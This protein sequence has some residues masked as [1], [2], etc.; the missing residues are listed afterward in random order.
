MILLIVCLAGWKVLL[1]PPFM[2]PAEFWP[3]IMPR[4]GVEQILIRTLWHGW[5][6]YESICKDPQMFS[7][8][9]TDNP[10]VVVHPGWTKYINV[11][12]EFNTHP[13]VY[14]TYVHSLQK[15]ISTTLSEKRSVLL[16]LPND[17]LKETV[18][19]LRPPSEVILVP[20]VFNRTDPYMPL[21][22]SNFYKLLTNH[23][24]RVE[25][26][27]EYGQYC[28]LALASSLADHIKIT[29]DD[30][31]IY[32]PDYKSKDTITKSLKEIN[33]AKEG[34]G[35]RAAFFL[36]YHF[37]PPRTSDGLNNLVQ[38]FSC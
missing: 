32:P 38:A 5:E 21:L 1:W 16:F 29:L 35:K 13:D 11:S 28:V 10:L 12:K 15:K 33:I 23:V 27:G 34:V 30:G 26:C 7:H 14:D 22:K 24:S 31:C 17:H 2:L 36:H 6:K 19:V 9:V 20:T 18:G 8:Y 37:L 4:R 3:E 25:M